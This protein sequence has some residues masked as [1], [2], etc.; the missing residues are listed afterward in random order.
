[1]DTNEIFS[2][3]KMWKKLK[4]TW[5]NMNL[6]AEYRRYINNPT[7]KKIGILSYKTF[8]WIVVVNV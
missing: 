2:I 7:Q 3:V 8:I 4:L 5:S 1:M 6:L